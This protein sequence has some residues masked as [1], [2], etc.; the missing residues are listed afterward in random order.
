MDH[1]DGLIIV[2]LKEG[3]KKWRIF[4]DFPSLV[5]MIGLILINGGRSLLASAKGQEIRGSEVHEGIC[6]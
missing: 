4:F 5:D 6:F 1:P 2:L 3:K